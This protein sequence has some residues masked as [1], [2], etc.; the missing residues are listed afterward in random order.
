[1]NPR[2]N[3]CFLSLY[4][5]EFPAQVAACWD[6]NLW[7]QAYV[8]TRQNTSN[9][10]SVVISVSEF[11]R[12]RGI[13]AGILVQKVKMKYRSTRVL[14]ENI[15]LAAKTRK[16][17]I[18]I[19]GQYTPDVLPQRSQGIVTLDLTGGK[20]FWGHHYQNLAHIIHKQLSDQI[21]FRTICMGSANSV[22]IAT[23]CANS[24]LPNQIKKCEKG[25]ESSILANINA[26]LLPNLSQETRTRLR[27][28]NLKT[29][30]DIR[31]M[32]KDFLISRL[33]RDGE[34]IYG[35]IQGLD[36]RTKKRCQVQRIQSE[37]DFATNSNDLSILHSAVQYISD[38]LCFKLRQH[39]KK[40]KSVTEILTFSDNKPY[41]QTYKLS[42]TT[43]SYSDIYHS[44][45][46]LFSA[47]FTRR[48]AVRKIEL[49]SGRLFTD[50]GQ[51]DLF[52]TFREKKHNQVAEA[53]DI[54][55]CN[56]GFNAI[57]NAEAL[58]FLHG[59]K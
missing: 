33:G 32:S 44:A 45:M 28:L 34:K 58:S 59:N 50:H 3:K 41:Q 38:Q 27:N 2:P 15:E 20:S 8:I 52:E 12:R 56:L 19:C 4:I 37:I 46:N 1:M 35:M 21:G 26:Q 10:R 14:K 5:P 7:N 47:L 24:A 43:W 42:R 16:E 53:L 49:R 40:T 9:D 22:L 55:R 48:V 36:F 25:C 30:E 29:V 54:I 57:Q 11:A 39:Q 31:S 23:L 6:R 51:L 18:R 17:I 13:H